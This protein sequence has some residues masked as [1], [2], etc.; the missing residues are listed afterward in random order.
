MIAFQEGLCCTGI[1]NWLD[2]EYRWLRKQQNFK[3]HQTY[4]QTAKIKFLCSR[5]IKFEVWISLE[6]K[7][8]TGKKKFSG[9]RKTY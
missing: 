6:L 8:V 3:T 7:K 1:V 2:S 5:Y 4:V 9:W